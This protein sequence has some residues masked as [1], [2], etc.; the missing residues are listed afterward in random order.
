MVQSFKSFLEER[1]INLIHDDPRKHQYK[2]EVHS[3]LTKAYEKIGGIH[4]SGFKDPDD[5]V[6]NI[7]MWKLAKKDGKVVAAALYKDKDGRKSV[8]VAT[9]GT[10]EG[11]K[12]LAHIAKHDLI[13]NRS[14]S[15]KSGPSLSFTKKSLGSDIVKHAIHPDYV[16]NIVS[17]E[18]RKPPENDPEIVKHPEL[19]DHFY[20]R[21]IGDEW[22]TKVML[23][24]PGKTIK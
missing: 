2:D 5:M 14:Y 3:L 24:T 18:I 8:A 17:D 9:N 21:K 23:G 4:G 19:K 13:N 12:H 16:K 7:H 22:H 10:E 1:Y 11:K 20:Q 15:E 6:K